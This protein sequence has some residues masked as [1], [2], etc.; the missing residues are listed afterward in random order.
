MGKGMGVESGSGVG[1]NRREGQ[2]AMR[3]NG[4]LYLIRMG[5][6]GASP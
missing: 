4:K 3:M 5:R 2:M 6:W 1:R